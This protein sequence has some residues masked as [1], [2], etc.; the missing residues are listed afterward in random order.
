MILYSTYYVIL[1]TTRLLT[2]N[3]TLTQ[4]SVAHSPHVVLL[5]YAEYIREDVCFQRLL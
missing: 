5:Q 3:T 1:A 4:F 2:Q